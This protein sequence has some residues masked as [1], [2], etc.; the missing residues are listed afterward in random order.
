VPKFAAEDGTF[1][2]IRLEPNQQWEKCAWM[3]SLPPARF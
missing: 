2:L 1:E 3:T